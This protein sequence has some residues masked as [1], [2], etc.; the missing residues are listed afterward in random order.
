M[1]RMIVA[2]LALVPFTAFGQFFSDIYEPDNSNDVAKV[3]LVGSNQTHTIHVAGDVDC[4]KFTA[5]A[6]HRYRI[7]TTAPGGAISTFDTVIY[8]YGSDKQTILA[9]NDDGGTYHFSK[10]EYTALSTGTL[11]VK[12]KEF[13]GA[14][15][16]T[17]TGEYVVTVTDL[18]EAGTGSGGSGGGE[19]LDCD[20]EGWPVR[21]G[22]YQDLTNQLGVLRWFGAI[23]NAYGK[24]GVWA[25][26]SVT[27]GQWRCVDG[28]PVTEWTALTADPTIASDPSVAVDAGNI[29]VAWIDR[30]SATALGRVY[31]KCWNGSSWIE[32]GSSASGVGLGVPNQQF[33]KDCNTPKVGVYRDGMP[34]VAYS[35]PIITMSGSGVSYIQAICVKKFEGDLTTG[36]GQWVGLDGSTNGVVPGATLAFDPDMEIDANGYP[37]VAWGDPQQAKIIVSRWTGSAWQQVGSAVGASPYAEKPVVTVDNNGTVYVAWRQYWLGDYMNYDVMQVYVAQSSG[38]SWVGLGGSYSSNGISAARSGGADKPADITISMGSNNWPMVCWQAG[39]TNTTSILLKQWNGSVWMGLDGS[40]LSPGVGGLGGLNLSP[41]MESDPWGRPAVSLGYSDDNGVLLKVFKIT[42]AS[43]P[44]FN[45]LNSAY[46]TT[47]AWISLSWNTATSAEPPSSFSNIT[48]HIYRSQQ[49]TAIYEGRPVLGEADVFSYE[50][51]SM[52]V[53]VGVTSLFWTNTLSAAEVDRWWGYGV[54][55]EINNMMDNNVVIKYACASNIVPFL[56]MPVTDTDG[57]GLDDIAYGGSDQNPTNADINANGVRDGDEVQLGYDPSANNGPLVSNIFYETFEDANYLNWGHPSTLDLW[58]RTL[59][60]PDPETSAIVG[61]NRHSTIYVMRC[62]TNSW[63]VPGSNPTNDTYEMGNNIVKSAL[64][65]PTNQIHPRTA[66]LTNLIVEWNEWVDTEASYDFCS[67]AVRTNNG[68]RPLNQG[69]LIARGGVSGGTTGWVHRTVD[70]T[71]WWR[72][73]GCP[74]HVQLRFELSAN[75]VN[76]HFRGWYIDDV[77][78]FGGASVRGTVRN[79]NGAPLV[80]AQVLAI[81]LGGVTNRSN[82]HLYVMPGKI[83][84]ISTTD[85]NGNYEIRGLYQGKYHIKAVAAGYGAEFWNGMLYDYVAFPAYENAFGQGIVTNKGVPDIRLI[86]PQGLADL[87]APNAWLRCDFELDPGFP[88]GSVAVMA[89]ATYPVRLDQYESTASLW[90]GA[91]GGV[92][93]T[94]ALIPYATTSVFPD[95]TGS[96]PDWVTNCV[97]PDVLSDIAEGEHFVSLSGLS[98]IPRISLPVRGGE[99]TVVQV[100]AANPSGGLLNVTTEGV[101]HPV[102]VDGV[103]AG[104]SSAGMIAGLQ[105]GYHEVSLRPSGDGCVVAPKIVLVPTSGVANVGF[106]AA[107][108]PGDGG[109]AY[110]STIDLY[111]NAVS[112]ATVYVDGRAVW[113]SIAVAGQGR[114]TTPILLRNLGTGTH[115]FSISKS[116]YQDS[117]IKSLAVEVGV[118]NNLQFVLFDA[119]RDYDKLGDSIE[120]NSYTNILIADRDDDTAGDGLGNYVK[121]EQYRLFGVRMSL[122]TNDS[123]ADGMTDIQEMGYDGLTNYLALS[124]IDENVAPGDSWVGVNFRGRFLEGINFWP[125]PVW[126]D[127]SRISIEGDEFATDFMIWWSSANGTPVMYYWVNS[128][129]PD[130][131]IVSESHLKGSEAFADTRPDKVDTDGEG[132]WDGFEYVYRTIT[133]IDPLN[134]GGTELDPDNDSLTNIREFLGVLNAASGNTNNWC[135]PGVADSDGDGMPD[136]WELNNGL[137]PRDPSDASLDYDADGLSNLEEWQFGTIP[138]NRDSDGD[139]LTDGLEV[140]VYSTD[141]NIRDTDA[142]GLPDGWEVWD[143]DGNIDRHNGGFFANWSPT[144]DTDGDGLPDG[145]LDWDSDGDGMPDGFEVLFD[146]ESGEIRP[147]GKRLDPTNP[148]DGAI[149]S[150][151]DGLS[152]LQEYLVLNGLYGT[153]P[154]LTSWNYSTDPFD[155]DSDDDG[156]PDGWEVA[157]QLHPMDPKAN[158]E[159][160]IGMIINYENLWIFGDLDGDGINNL[161]E[162]NLRF[163]YNPL[164]NAYAIEGSCDPRINDT[165]GDGLWDGEEVKAFRSNPLKQDTD[166]DTL[167]DGISLTDPSKWGEVNTDS[168]GAS[169]NHYDRALND[170][171]MCTSTGN[172][173]LGWHAYW[174][175]VL[176]DKTPEQVPVA[177]F[178]VNNRIIIPVANWPAVGGWTNDAGTYEWSVSPISAARPYNNVLTY[179]F[180]VPTNDVYEIAILHDGTYMREKVKLDFGDAMQTA[181]VNAASAWSYASAKIMYRGIHTLQILDPENNPTSDYNKPCRITRIYI[182]PRVLGRT[183]GSDAGAALTGNRPVAEWPYDRPERRWGATASAINYEIRDING[184]YSGQAV[185]GI[186]STNQLLAKAKQ[187]V[188][189]GGRNGSTWYTNSWTFCDNAAWRPG[190]QTVW[191]FSDMN[192]FFGTAVGMSDL[193][194][195]SQPEVEQYGY[196]HQTGGQ[197]WQ[198]DE[199]PRPGYRDAYTYYGLDASSVAN[200]WGENGTNNVYELPYVTGWDRR[201]GAFDYWPYMNSH[202]R[203]EVYN[204]A[205]MAN[206][207]YAYMPKEDYSQPEFAWQSDALGYALVDPTTPTSVATNI[208]NDGAGVGHLWYTAGT[209]PTNYVVIGAV[210]IRNVLNTANEYMQDSMTNMVAILSLTTKPNTTTAGPMDIRLFGEVS[211]TD[212]SAETVMR[213]SGHRTYTSYFFKTNRWQ[214]SLLTIN[215]RYRGIGIVKKFGDPRTYTVRQLTAEQATIDIDVTDIVHEIFMLGHDDNNFWANPRWE[216]GNSIGFILSS[217]NDMFLPIENARLSIKLINPDWCDNGDIDV[218]TTTLVQVP[219]E[220]KSSASAILDDYSM[221]MFGGLDGSRVLDDTWTLAGNSRGYVQQIGL[222]P[223]VSAPTA[224]WGHSMVGVT[225]KNF[226]VLFGGFD[227]NNA[228]LNDLWIWSGGRWYQ[229]TDFANTDSGTSYPEPNNK[230]RPRGGAVLGVVGGHPCLFGGTDGQKYFNDMWVLEQMGSIPSSS[231]QPWRWLLVEPDGQR[232]AWSNT[233]PDKITP[234]PRAFAASAVLDNKIYVFGGRT[235][236]MPTSTDTDNDEVADNVEHALGGHIAGRDPTVNALISASAYLNLTGTP[237]RIPFAYRTIGGMYSDRTPLDPVGTVAVPSVIADF[238]SLSHAHNLF[239]GREEHLM[240]SV[241]EF[242]YEGKRTPS[243]TIMDFITI[244][245]YDAIV[246]SYSDL[247]WHPLSGAGQWTLGAPDASG[248]YGPKYA[249]SGR[250]CFGTGLTGAYHTNTVA[251]LYSP[252]FDL[253]NPPLNNF[254]DDTNPNGYYLVFYEW[255]NLANVGDLVRIECVRPST[256]ADVA[257]RKTGSNPIRSIVSVLPNRNNSFNTTGE[258]RRVVVPLDTLFNETNLFLRFVMQSGANSPGSC[259]GWFIDD[260]AILQAAEMTGTYSDHFNSPVFLMGM[261][262]NTN[263]PIQTTVANVNGKFGFT[264]LLPSGN[265]KVGTESWNGVSSTNAGISSWN[266]VFPVD[267]NSYEIVVGITVNSPATL[268]W[269]TAI[270]FTYAVQ[271]STPETIATPTPWTTLTTITATGNVSSFTDFASDSNP[272]RFY[273]VILI[274]P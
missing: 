91:T 171:W 18:G 250:W 90:N 96:I 94:A 7:E 201:L 97:A 108:I 233:N 67:V 10:I 182:Y 143:T 184:I 41:F 32:L 195:G 228:P 187:F 136:G 166:G 264:G 178:D 49:S 230:P 87:T 170:L 186:G 81:G 31:L 151:G 145:P 39:E 270:G 199:R 266:V 240:N 191:A 99:I 63:G 159:V 75:S 274:L 258:W 135:N 167:L 53:P 247:W 163:L 44:I 73:A 224:R 213:T 8:L 259:G 70:L 78:V 203:A 66:G 245:G 183:L 210:H 215:D 164:A 5:Q 227:A 30:E 118:T 48:Y 117:E 154:A 238:E 109:Y 188:V 34:V 192:A 173:E 160:D 60:D 161:N 9:M 236:T 177:A 146:V 231:G 217:L 269:N 11:Y 35:Q 206:L 176:T 69:W 223:G 174:Q 19:V 232:H 51:A 45:G 15:G 6:T 148:Y 257:T 40:D 168:T 57:D 113:D 157:K 251:E 116:G 222:T 129:G 271:Y 235:G 111:G 100:D 229:I 126:P 142:D 58:H 180:S 219:Y 181:P 74:D 80:G 56:S 121:F 156:M 20:D 205:P 122:S 249:H 65:T 47:Q 3:I 72:N 261:N 194:S 68:T 16:A 253:S 134:K 36:A 256:T 185:S 27:S 244:S 272:S 77:R 82:G 22:I 86:S 17:P 220:R 83:F 21:A 144:T 147:V 226:A 61:V 112:N 175:Q 105:G 263:D 85:S 2:V 241:S 149:D 50:V 262:G 54:R 23:S 93:G 127:Q 138:M 89:G 267:L 141:P 265:Y 125:V 273:R 137:T 132:M 25:E 33:E 190:A 237:E 155:P 207:S 88:R 208:M 179:Y 42:G 114:T 103:L 248:T 120:A 133:G 71:A 198:P 59:V 242:P 189:L 28:A 243:P 107:E 169:T 101:S 225:N 150:D 55:A 204:L 239:N 37:V 211:L 140:N 260:V 214:G 12:I 38:G 216:T 246:S 14:D 79:I 4:V 24:N 13:F 268:T 95:M 193:V 200:L 152:N 252:L 29:F 123:D 1:W 62:S 196:R 124:S 92:S 172:R 26:L 76:N 162:Y 139:G 52:T 202:D 221:V 218:V 165:D 110:I 119:D 115:K 102:Y 98:G 130:I 212:D 64:D 209:D 234:A 153:P 106:G 43:R 131:D 84:A 197:I 255:L 46:G 158:A 254:T 128:A 104:N